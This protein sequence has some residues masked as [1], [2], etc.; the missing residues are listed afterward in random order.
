MPS[1]VVR[2]RSRDRR[3]PTNNAGKLE[4][5]KKNSISLKPILYTRDCQVQSYEQILQWPTTK[6]FLNQKNQKFSNKEVFLAELEK[7]CRDL[8]QRL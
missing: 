1:T 2:K 8:Y 3:D 7:R 5:L 6:S 4:K